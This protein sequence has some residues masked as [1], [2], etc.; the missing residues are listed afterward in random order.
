MTDRLSAL[1][2]E[3]A[4]L[5]EAWILLE[6]KRDI[7]I[8]SKVNSFILRGEWEEEMPTAL[9]RVQGMIE[10]INAPAPGG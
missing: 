4:R 5:A 10:E 3:R 8:R 9:V 2:K 6:Q 1:L 7:T